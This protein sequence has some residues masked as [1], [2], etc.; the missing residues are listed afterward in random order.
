MA[1]FISKFK[2]LMSAGRDNLSFVGV[3]VIV[4]AAILV[5][6]ILAEKLI[7]KGQ[8][9]DVSGAR[10]LAVCG[11]MS[12]LAAVL[13]LF[14][15]PLFFA[16]TFYK[17]DFSEILVM[18]GTFTLGPTAGVIIELVKVLLKLVFKGTTTA[19]VGDLANFIIGCS[20]VVPAS[21]IY[22]VK[23]TKKTALVG[24][25]TGTAV[26]TVFGSMFNAVYLLPKFSQLYGLP[27][28]QI[29]AMGTAIN[30]KITSVTTMALF[31]VAPFNIVK[32]VLVTVITM[33]LYKHISPMLKNFGQK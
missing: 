5:I 26:M 11:I 10:Y 17:L 8:K 31:A 20:M 33:L 21:V 7:H 19:F 14:E 15:I 1:L 30:S 24:M 12:A 25:I 4:V 9:K 22:Y 28:E 16:P 2:E 18:I 27:L 3:C 32:G 29:V 23:K 6:A 13:M